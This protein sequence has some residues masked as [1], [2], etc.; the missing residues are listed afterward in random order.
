[1][2]A[3]IK[4]QLIEIESESII[5]ENNGIGYRLMTAP[6][7]LMSFGALGEEICA[8]TSMVFRQDGFLLY[9]FP[10][11]AEC[12]L[13]EL[14]QTVTGVGPKVA[15]LVLA[16]FSPDKFALAVLAG[17]AKAL[18]A[19]KGLGKKGA[20]RL[21]LELK[22]KLK[23]AAIGNTFTKTESIDTTQSTAAQVSTMY[24]ECMSA[25]LVLG[26]SP[27]LAKEVIDKTFDATLSLEEN[28]RSALRAA[29]RQ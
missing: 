4:G 11:Q 2:Y 10:S 1:M 26:Y 28:V 18:T 23:N 9:A 25:M 16:T 20:E 12:K 14:L 21:V 19:V 17:D 24:E 6:Q 13:F 7:L 27:M 15:S 5:V 22:D 8:Y 3:Y 29:A